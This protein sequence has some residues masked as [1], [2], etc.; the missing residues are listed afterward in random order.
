MAVKVKEEN[1]DSRK[2]WGLFI[3]NELYLLFVFISGALVNV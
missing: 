2:V 1:L 3:F